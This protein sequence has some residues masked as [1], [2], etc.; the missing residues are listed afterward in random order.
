MEGTVQAEEAAGVK[1]LKL[2]QVLHL[3]DPRHLVRDHYGQ[4][5]ENKGT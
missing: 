1:V 3:L 4:G 5:V 2:G